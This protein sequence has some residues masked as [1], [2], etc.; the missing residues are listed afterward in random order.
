M[1]LCSGAAPVEEWNR[2]FGGKDFDYPTFIAQTHDGGYM[3]T[4]S[5]K[6]ISV[7]YPVISSGWVVKIDKK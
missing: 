3:I 2:T 5:T 4:G 7:D 1:A 6:S